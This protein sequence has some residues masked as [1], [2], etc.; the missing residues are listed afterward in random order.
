MIATAATTQPV[1]IAACILNII[2]FHFLPAFATWLRGLAAASPLLIVFLFLLLFLVFFN[3]R[4]QSFCCCIGIMTNTENFIF[5]FIRLKFQPAVGHINMSYVCNVF[6][7]AY[8]SDISACS[9]ILPVRV[10][11]RRGLS[12]SDTPAAA[13]RSVPGTAF[14]K[15]YVLKI[16]AADLQ[17]Q[18]AVGYSCLNI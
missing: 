6:L 15:V 11:C 13:A 2:I 8:P 18:L 14:V 1:I 10:R 17:Q 16:F 3:H 4:L 9:Q 5:V 7:P 12:A